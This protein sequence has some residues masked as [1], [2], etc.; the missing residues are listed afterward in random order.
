M[1]WPMVAIAGAQAAYSMYQG[2]QGG[3][4]AKKA[5]KATA[6]LIRMETEIAA[7]RAE[8]DM[9]DLMKQGRGAAY[10][11]GVEMSGSTD[12]YLRKMQYRGQEGINDIRRVGAAQANA[13]KKGGQ[14][15]G[16][17][18]MAQGIAGAIG[19]AAGAAGAVYGNQQAT[20]PLPGG[21]S[22]GGTSGSMFSWNTSYT[23]PEWKY[24]P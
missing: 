4:A 15:T 11:S 18:L 12:A 1:V 10:A 22:G 3:K 19:S 24:Q 8:R 16:S 6:D 5:G 17:G 23:P 9:S 20:R 13:A 2:Y 21:T 7:K 14:V